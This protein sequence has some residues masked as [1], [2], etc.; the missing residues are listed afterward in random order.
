[1]ASSEAQW[2]PLSVPPQGDCRPPGRSL[3]VLASG[4]EGTGQEEEVQVIEWLGS[5]VGAWVMVDVT[6]HLA[7]PR[8]GKA[9][10]VA[11]E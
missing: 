10:V 4:L 3:W 11:L 7:R 6:A 9:C 2:A 1:M 8:G 5:G